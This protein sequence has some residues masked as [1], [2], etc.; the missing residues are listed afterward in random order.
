MRGGGG[1][2]EHRSPDSGLTEARKAAERQRV[3]GEGNDGE[4]SSA[5]SLGAR[6]W[7]KEEQWKEGMSGRPFIGLEGERGGRAEENGWRR[8]RAI[9]MVEAAVQG[10]DRRVVVGS[11]EGE[12]LRL[13]QERKGHREVEREHARRWQ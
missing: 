9:M 6:E 11:D 3:G 8:W 10:G 5:G 1:N 7:G 12:V 2:G 4:S 13:L